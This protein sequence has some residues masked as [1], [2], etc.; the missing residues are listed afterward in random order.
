[1][2]YAQKKNSKIPLTHFNLTT[3]PRTDTRWTYDQFVNKFDPIIFTHHD[4][5]LYVERVMSEKLCP[6]V[7][8]YGFSVKGHRR[9]KDLNLTQAHD[10]TH[11]FP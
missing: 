3:V 11:F 10:L 9:F 8:G 6:I 7:F 5:E 1:M 4:G 2:F